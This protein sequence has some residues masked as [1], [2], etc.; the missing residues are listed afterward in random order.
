MADAHKVLFWQ[1]GIVAY[2]LGLLPVLSWLG[3]QLTVVG[4][5]L[6]AAEMERSK[7]QLVP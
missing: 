7:F 1:F 3:T 6:W 5:A 2:V 4:G